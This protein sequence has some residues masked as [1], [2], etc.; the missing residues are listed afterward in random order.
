MANNTNN[1]KPSAI[2]KSGF[3]T[4]LSTLFG[5]RRNTS[6]NTPNNVTFTKVDVD[7]NQRISQALL[8]KINDFNSNGPLSENL[9]RI[10]NF[11]LNDNTDSLLEISNRKDRV[12]QLTYAVLNDP[13][14]G[15][16]V[17]LYADEATQ[18]DVQG[19]ILQIDSPDPR[20]TKAMYK[21][22]SDWGITSPRVRATIKDL[23][24]YGDAF[25]ANKVSE[26][27]VERIIP[28]SQLQVTNRLE[29]NPVEALER[30]KRQEGS[31]YSFASK[32]YLINQMFQNIDDSNDFADMFDTKLFGFSITDEL[33]V[34]PWAITH[35]RVGAES[36]QFYPFGTS[37]ILGTL[38]P[39]K[40]TTS[41]IALQA[42]A[43]VMNFPTTIYKVKTTPNMDEATQ[44]AVVNKVREQYDNIG[45][46]PKAGNSE[47]YTVNTKIWAPDGLLDVEVKKADVDVGHTEDIKIYQDRTA[48]AAGLPKSFY[49]DEWYGFGNSGKSL[50]QQY[51]PFGRKTYALQAAFLDSVADLFRIHFA[52]TG[53]FDFRV[54]FTISMKFPAEEVDDSKNDSRGKSIEIAK[55][56]VDLIKSTIG[57]SE[58]E[59]LPSSIV[60][61][62]ISKYTFL[63][64][65]D[66][67]RWTKNAGYSKG[68]EGDDFSGGGFDGGGSSHKGTPID[69]DRDISDSDFSDESSPTIEAPPE[70]DLTDIGSAENIPQEPT[71]ES[72]KKKFTNGINR[73]REAQI[74]H[75]YNESQIRLNEVYFKTLKENN[76][77]DFIRHS[78]HVQCYNQIPSCN[79]LMLQTLYKESKRGSNNKLKESF[80]K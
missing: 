48:V 78:Q 68:L 32:N 41:T 62:I 52:I 37:P 53:E 56:V 8:N 17:E 34:P 74:L 42:L 38:A 36:G 29:F 18:L 33:V 64:P 45:V 72:R 21:L 15:R 71:E 79:D 73:L 47:V 26:N 20:M 49:S 69:F 40:L 77:T 24:E 3:N 50:A 23:A 2:K 44:F 12:D 1:I 70:E 57:A 30:K 59:A 28:L 43:R 51:K 75:N 61:D 22:I 66:I 65:V 27:G 58:D 14:I 35:F 19:T 6:K 54:P 76:I 67:V 63:D 11:W 46:S 39:F 7:S 55:S 9:E 25:W 16:T 80:R 4:F 31:F 10:F 13:Y 5:W 60:R